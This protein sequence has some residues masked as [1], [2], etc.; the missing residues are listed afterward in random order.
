MPIYVRCPKCTKDAAVSRAAIGQR[1]KCDACGT[2]FPV[3]FGSGHLVVEWGLSET[4]RHIPLAPPH[5]V[6]IGRA[7][8]NTLQLRGA[9]VSRHHARI[10]WE[11]GGWVL[12]DAGSGN[13]VRLNDVITREARLSNGDSIIVGE[14][15]LRVTIG[16]APNTALESL[17]RAEL[18][19]NPAAFP[20][21]P[22]LESPVAPLATPRA[23]DPRERTAVG[24][25]PTGAPSVPAVVSSRPAADARPPVSAMDAAMLPRP[26]AHSVTWVYWL[27]GACSIVL[28]GVILG[29]LLLWG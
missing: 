10:D 25:R 29:M 5:A 6:T 13:G 16:A 3:P 18:G 22:R 23:A 27:I 28:A 21:D 17:A 14:F 24:M 20:G 26:A 4:G 7:D 2:I 8:D 11:Q 19:A 1:A 9:S 12:R 15:V